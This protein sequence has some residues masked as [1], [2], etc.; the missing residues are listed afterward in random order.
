MKKKSRLLV[1]RINLFSGFNFS[2]MTAKRLRFAVCGSL[3]LATLT[4]PLP[5]VA[6]NGP[7]LRQFIGVNLNAED[8]WEKAQ[9]F[10]NVREFH[11]WADDIS[12][13]PGDS[14]C[15]FEPGS[16]QKLRW[17]N[18]YNQ[19][20]YINYDLFYQALPQKVSVVTQG[21][22]PSMLGGGFS[23]E[24]QDGKPICR[25]DVGTG[26]NFYNPAY[27][28]EPRAYKQQTIWQSFLAA[29]Y[30]AAP[31]GGFPANFE[32]V[33][34]N[35]I[36]A[37]DNIGL[38]KGLVRYIENFNEHDA[39]WQG[40]DN[41]NRNST[42]PAN[43][44]PS[45]QLTTWFFRPEEYAAMLSANYDG[46]CK[47]NDFR[48][49]D[50]NGAYWGIKNLSS[51]VQ[52]VMSGTADLRQNYIK[53]VIRQFSDP[54]SKAY[55]PCGTLPFDVINMHHY[56]TEQ[57]PAIGTPEYYNILNG[58]NFF[59]F[60]RGVNPEAP[61]E[62]L[63]QRIRNTLNDGQG[64]NLL[65]KK[66]WIT[67]LGYDSDAV[68]GTSNV[69]TYSIGP[70]DSYTV[71]G[72]W[73]TRCIFELLAST[74]VLDRVYLYRMQDDDAGLGNAQFRHTGIIDQFG[75]PKKSWYHIMTQIN[76]LGDYKYVE[77][78]N[79]DART[80][81]FVGQNVSSPGTA[82]PYDD[83]RIYKFLKDGN[84]EEPV[85]VLWAPY[86]QNKTYDG[87]LYL[88]S[89]ALGAVINSVLKIEVQDFDENG[90]RTL[91]P[92][93]DIV[94]NPGPER[95]YLIKNLH[96]SETPIYLK[97]NGKTDVSDPVAQPV[98]NLQVS[99][100]C[101]DAARLSW[102][103]LTPEVNAGTV[104]NTWFQ[105]Y[106]AP[107]SAFDPAPP[108]FDLSRLTTVE[109]R[110]PG[111]FR[112]CVITGL[113]PGI[114]YYF[115]V[116]P[117]RNVAV[118]AEAAVQGLLPD[119]LSAGSLVETRHYVQG[120]ING[121][122]GA[123]TDCLLPIEVA[124]YVIAPPGMEG[125]VSEA[126][127]VNRTS[128]QKCAELATQPSGGINMSENGPATLTFGIDFKTPKF[129]KTI[130]FNHSTGGPGKIKIEV[131]EDCC[132]KWRMVKE[133]D[134]RGY[135]TW[136]TIAN[137]QVGQRRIEKVRFTITRYSRSN[138]ILPRVYF[139]ASAAPDQC[140]DATI[141][142]PPTLIGPSNASVKNIDTRSAIVTWAP[143]KETVAGKDLPPA[144]YLLRS[145]VATTPQGVIINPKET[146]KDADG[147]ETVLEQPLSG[148]IPGTLYYVD[149]LIDPAVLG[150]TVVPSPAIRLKFKTNELGTGT[151]SMDRKQPAQLSLSPNPA[152]NKV[153]INC[154]ET[155]YST[156]TLTYSNGVHIRSGEVTGDTSL[157]LDVADMSSG[158]YIVTFMGGQNPPV[159]KLF[160]VQ[161]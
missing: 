160:V 10:A 78:P 21:T 151:R 9:V 136:F 131:M 33:A 56:P 25:N 100:L 61:N 53:E 89:S 59:S 63:K 123:S 158:L 7:T 47:N 3:L 85:F 107:K 145:G 41:V 65:G 6:Q 138:L 155:G 45:W 105:V 88:S 99:S 32:N 109:E 117:V 92:A 74:S 52:V 36:V 67:E 116:I 60:G 146:Y 26:S 156:W 79:N 24:I 157:D 83:P 50:G 122:G 153:M 91:I 73:L 18:S 126:F 66:L 140:A 139:C 120:S 54:S 37:P 69:K 43:W 90:K 35:Y 40:A 28:S 76:V 113:Q 12:V 42:T 93:V 144:R 20:R 128:A 134:I 143:A 103:M 14:R 110:L 17:N 154:S 106:Y 121:C 5:L 150:C 16:T 8:S 124:G 133:L 15:P 142:Q 46:H 102:E 39:S 29:R 75:K 19:N 161:H 31:L 11:L 148:L 1:F 129:L 98:K 119:L 80:K 86:A 94:V 159:S 44:V 34:S 81:F 82:L 96:L 141:G 127:G 64:L 149:L 108:S 49:P 2:S 4:P 57:H 13:L 147:G 135:N 22:A 77:T 71:Q 115:F 97:I 84:T 68:G 132:N 38:G 95:G 62:M 70:F 23:A 125:S 130:Y 101:C 111:S 152:D 114:Q 118:T 112:E 72:Q 51:E 104:T 58:V 30:G 87:M 27:H 48:V 55:R 137:T